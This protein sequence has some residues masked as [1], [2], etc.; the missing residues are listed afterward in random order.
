LVFFQDL[1]HIE[2]IWTL[3]KEWEGL[4]SEWKVSKFSDIKTE[5]MESTAQSVYKKLNRYNKELKV[6]FIIYVYFLV[7]LE[8]CHIGNKHPCKKNILRTEILSYQ[9]FYIKLYFNQFL[10]LNLY[11]Y[12]LCLKI[13][14]F[15]ENKHCH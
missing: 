13:H 14:I 7:T 8:N 1:E 3:N 10:R 6:N 11:D 4:W 9:Y 2:Q 12:S 5:T 15:M